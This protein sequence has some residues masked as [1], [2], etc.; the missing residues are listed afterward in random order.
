MK[1]TSVALSVA[2]LSCF[3]TTGFVSADDPALGQSFNQTQRNCGSG[4]CAFHAPNQ[5]TLS[6]QQKAFQNAFQ[7]GANRANGS[8]L[9]C[10]SGQC[11]HLHT[12]PPYN[13]RPNAVDSVN[14]SMNSTSAT[15]TRTGRIDWQRDLRKAAQLAREQRKPLVVNVTAKWCHY[16][17]QMKNETWSQRSVIDQ[18]NRQFVAVNVDADAHGDIVAMLGVKSLPAVVVISPDAT[19]LSKTTGYKSASELTTYL[20]RTV[21][22]PVNPNSIGFAGRARR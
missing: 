5:N 6:L 3:L 8:D 4:G 22:G 19:I 14:R 2:A 18:V 16:C 15:V 7:T 20:Q 11:S 21:R 10:S 13:A 9:A 12:S 17:V 1:M